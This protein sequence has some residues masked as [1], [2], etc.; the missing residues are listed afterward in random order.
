MC[1][2]YALLIR[3]GFEWHNMTCHIHVSFLHLEK[4]P[5]WTRPAIL[6]EYAAVDWHMSRVPPEWQGYKAV[7]EVLAF[8]SQLHAQPWHLVSMYSFQFHGTFLLGLPE[9]FVLPS[10]P[11]PVNTAETHVLRLSPVFLNPTCTVWFHGR[12]WAC[13]SASR[14]LSPPDVRQLSNTKAVTG[15]FATAPVFE[16]YLGYSKTRFQP[17]SAFFFRMRWTAGWWMLPEQRSPSTPSGLEGQLLLLLLCLAG[18]TA[19]SKIGIYPVQLWRSDNPGLYF[20]HNKMWEYIF[21]LQPTQIRERS[22][23]S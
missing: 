7:V 5:A 3:C 8:K 22:R 23:A 1:R 18:L 10:S 20:I 12:T 2:F 16:G 13:T 17:Q 4:W 9:D 14:V 6:A 15:H 19:G 11:L 21:L